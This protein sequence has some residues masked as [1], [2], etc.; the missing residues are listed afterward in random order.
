MW[1]EKA[2]SD[3]AEAEQ[4]A[5]EQQQFDLGDTS[6]DVS[7]DLPIETEA[8]ALPPT[9]PAPPE[10]PAHSPRLVSMAHRLGITAEQIQSLSPE[11]LEQRI[12]YEHAQQQAYLAGRFDSQPSSPGAAPPPSV[13]AEEEITLDF[14][15]DPETGRPYTEADFDPGLVHAFKQIERSR[16][17]ETRRLEA[18]LAQYRQSEQHRHVQTAQQQADSGFADLGEAYADLFGKQT[19]D[20]LSPSSPEYQR[21]VAVL[22]YLQ[23]NPQIQGTLRERVAAAGKLLYG[24][25]QKP[26]Q[27]KE[28]SQRQ[29][30]WKGAKLATP[31]TT[32]AAPRTKTEADKLRVVAS[33]MRDMGLASEYD[34][35]FYA[36]LPE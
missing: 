36:S 5:Q 17:D 25:R 20:Q 21:R 13:P 22:S 23:H 32:P 31:G 29:D 6:F 30:V 1:G 11:D 34:E 9:E 8:K 15:K 2:A 12:D 18:E 7:Y 27:S 19:S 14:G 33:A 3:V 24:E 10:T 26:E 28:L 35:D 16:R 4:Q